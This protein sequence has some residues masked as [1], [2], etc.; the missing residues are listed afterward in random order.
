MKQHTTW[1]GLYRIV[2]LAVV[3][4]LAVIL[5][6]LWM[7]NSLIY[8]APKYPRGDWQAAKRLGWEEVDFQSADGTKLH[9]WY[10]EAANPSQNYL[11]YCHGNGEN[12]AFIGEYLAELSDTYDLNIFAFDYRGYGR[13][14]G[15]P[16]EAGVLADAEAA[17]QWLVQRSGLSP[18]QLILMGRSLGGS[19]AIHLAARHGARGLI[20]Q[21]TFTSLP[22]AAARLYPWAPVHWLMR[23]RYDS[24][25]QMAKYDGPLLQSH[26]AADT[27]VPLDLGQKL[28]AAA[29]GPKKL[30]IYPGLNHND[31]EPLKYG[32]E[33]AA[34]LKSL[35]PVKLSR[36][37]S[38]ARS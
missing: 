9:G 38:A 29:K 12:I 18:N 8:P 11:L 34:F 3:T 28:H 33:L 31:P 22:D 26:G 5:M 7:E 4:Y 2:R 13:S 6:L 16:H 14:D 37:E 27:L 20:I 25:S 23:N 21:S 35:P 10:R 1:Q 24:L 36:P 17:H 32:D 19:V 30:L 15:S